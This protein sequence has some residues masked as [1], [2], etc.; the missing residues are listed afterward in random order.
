[1]KYNSVIRILVAALILFSNVAYAQTIISG[2]VVD[3]SGIAL[4]G[5]NVIE[6][7][8]T[9]GTATDVDGLYTLKVQ[10]NAT[11]V[12]S[13]IGYEKLEVPVNGRT[14][15]DIIMLPDINRLDEIVVVGYGTQ[16]RSD[17]TGA[18]TSLSSEFLEDRPI[19][20][21]EEA[22]QGQVAGLSISSTGGQPGAA[23]KMN[24]R[25]ISSVSGNSQPLIVV[26]GFPMNQVSTSGGG[27]LEQFSSQIGAFAYINPDDIESIEVLKDASATAIY[28]N[29]GANGVIMI[30]TKQGKKDK[31]GITF[32]TYFGSQVMDRRIDVMNFGEYA[33]YQQEI[34]PNNR[35]FTAADGTPYDFPDA[36]Q[37][38][39]DWQDE[40]YRRGSTQNYSLSLQGKNQ[41]TSYSFSASYNKNES[42]LIAT[43]FEKLTARLALDHQFTKNVTVGANI[44]YSNIINNGVPTDGREGTAAGIVIGALAENPFRMDNNTQARFRRAGVS[45]QDIDNF[46]S[47]HLSNPDNIANNTKLDKNINRLIGNMYADITFTEWLSFR[48]TLGLD[49]FTLKDQQFYS[50]QTPWGNLNNGIATAAN[51]NSSN[52]VNENYFTASKTLNAHRI[53]LV[54]GFSYQQSVSDFHRTEARS[55]QNEV[56]GYNSLQ[57]ASEFLSSSAADELVMLSYL[58][59]VNY[60]YDERFLTTFTYRRDGTSRFQKNKWGDFYSG[61]VAWNVRNEAFLENSRLISTLKLRA[62]LGQIGNASVPVQGALL[63]QQYSNYTFNGVV[64]NGVSPQNLE[65]QN[66]T[67]ETTTQYN[68]GIDFGIFNGAL[69]FTADYFVKNTTDLLLLAPVSISTGFSQ[70]WFN[71]GEIQNSGFEFSADYRYQSRGGFAWNSRFNLSTIQSEIMALGNDGEPIFIDVNFDAI[72]TDEII[73]QVGG[74]I[75]DLYGYQTDGIYLPG[76]FNP[77]GTPADGV[78]TA[79]A[80]EQAGDIKYSDLSGP[81]GV[82]DGVI[83]G[84]DRTILGNTMPDIYGSWSNG[85]SF[86]G[87]ELDII[88]QYSYGNEVFNATNTRIASFPG[89]DQNQTSDWLDRWTPE[90]PNGTQYAR[91][92]SLRPADY[93][94]EDGS[95][96]R[97]QT[98][99]IGY[100][101]PSAW[102]APIKIKGA[103]VYLAAN[104]L[105]LFTNYTGYDPE[106]TSNQVDYRYPFVQ[107]FDYGG[108][109][110]AK[111]FIAGLNVQ[112]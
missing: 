55:F 87:I 48:S 86:K 38:N 108:F 57:G 37:M 88:L 93:L 30:T 102:L 81:D 19:T 14:T 76:D 43:D 110:R 79:G 53:N 47:A 77:D 52:L 97:L 60:S 17:V 91:V 73:L 27:N 18:V 11:I 26:D 28:G 70:G 54:A 67:W 100:N 1:M 44:T 111:T 36:D 65:N 96:I 24:I 66:L 6:M 92:P 64:V 106:V 42:V 20:N 59:R 99:R 103:K 35:L 58:G 83:D 75:N 62:S 22:L 31:S 98:V 82:P 32:S 101:L 8:T 40:I 72:S 78:P 80:G 33:K 2:R 41:A 63:D 39:L 56:L 84:F 21:F 89:G 49:F 10:E 95:F 29:R 90:N 107:G 74:S 34:N 9:N 61:A 45:Q 25:G 68:A 23:T 13:F 5:V 112:F 94:V 51:N 12:F 16:K 7:N 3:E 46:I 4:P 69:N 105:A 50:S 71:I 85:I 15:I 104:N 109:P